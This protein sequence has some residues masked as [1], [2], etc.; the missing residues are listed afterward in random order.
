MSE[1]DD[2]KKVEKNT[3]PPKMTEEDKLKE[4]LR[5]FSSAQ[6]AALAGPKSKPIQVKRKTLHSYINRDATAV[7]LLQ[8]ATSAY[9]DEINL[10]NRNFQ[11][12]DYV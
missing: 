9:D 12:G 1:T 10:Y 7:H 3:V 5:G 8:V 11:V 4:S 6:L 2:K